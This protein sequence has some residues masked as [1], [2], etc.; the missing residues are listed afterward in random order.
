MTRTGVASRRSERAGDALPVLD[1]SFL[2]DVEHEVPAAV[3]RMKEIL[4]QGQPMLVPVIVAV[5]FAAGS[6]DPARAWETFRESYLLIDFTEALAERASMLA[7]TALRK[8]S[9]PGWSD[10]QVAATALEH[11][12]PVVT[13]DGKAMDAFDGVSVE[14]Y[15]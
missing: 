6:R 1:T 2:I 13:R 7:W 14:T 9:F 15:S 3:R 12:E 8:G 10:T 11:G 5:E 4:E